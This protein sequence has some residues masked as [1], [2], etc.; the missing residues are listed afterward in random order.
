MIHRVIKWLISR[1]SEENV[2]RCT[3]MMTLDESHWQMVARMINNMT[4][5][6]PLRL[7][8]IQT[9]M[10]GVNTPHFASLLITIL[11]SVIKQWVLVWN[12]PSF[13]ATFSIPHN[14]FR[15]RFKK[16]SNGVHQVSSKQRRLCS[17]GILAELDGLDW[18]VKARTTTDH[19]KS[20]LL[21]S[22]F[23]SK[24]SFKLCFREHYP[25]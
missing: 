6:R 20:Q 17:S 5:A 21:Q 9:T 25:H 2:N 7:F 4:N 15:K 18:A 19:N 24:T 23:T 12:L 1:Q 14:I 22:S 3:N 13:D 8:P 11:P 16:P 10:A